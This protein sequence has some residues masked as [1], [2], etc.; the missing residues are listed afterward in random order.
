[1]T[2][3]HATRG[4]R[5]YR[6]YVTREPS[7]EEPAWR[8]GA[9]DIEA[10]VEGRVKALLSDADRVRRIAIGIDPRQAEAVACA[11]AQMAGAALLPK[12]SHLGL[13]RIDLHED[14]VDMMIGER[15]LLRACGMAVPG[16]HDAVIAIAASVTRVRRG[17]ELKLVVPGPGGMPSRT[18]DPQLVDLVA[19][20]FTLRETMLATGKPV[21]VVAAE[22][23]KCR[24]RMTRLLPL[25]W[26]APDIVEAIVQGSQPSSCRTPCFPSSG[27]SSA[28]CSP[29][30][31]HGAMDQRLRALFSLQRCRISPPSRIPQMGSASSPIETPGRFRRCQSRN[32]DALASRQDDRASKARRTAPVFALLQKQAPECAGS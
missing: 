4:S 24:K 12:I 22:A 7:G 15:E 16:D 14:R 13:Q 5:R 18:P 30:L 11:A 32:G 28:R 6:Y 3:T 31:Q 26:L 17:N 21:S 29:D 10:I 9:H 2:A 23:G 1:M 19:E 27:R 8:I 25:A 20:A